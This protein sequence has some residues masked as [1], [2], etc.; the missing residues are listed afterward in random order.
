[1]ASVGTNASVIDIITIIPGV[2]LG[3]IGVVGTFAGW[4]IR[5][6]DKRFDHIQD[7]LD[8]QD[9]STINLRERVA[10]VEGKLGIGE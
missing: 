3:V 8:R 7:H 1:M 2:I 6:L 10:K 9:E 5:R 4:I